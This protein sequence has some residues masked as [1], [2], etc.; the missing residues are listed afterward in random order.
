VTL[1]LL[2]LEVGALLLYAGVK[3]VSVQRLLVGDNTTVTAN[4]SLSS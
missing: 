1:A 3:G 4:K 2:V